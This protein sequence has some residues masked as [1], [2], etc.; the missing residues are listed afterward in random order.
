MNLKIKQ[1]YDHSHLEHLFKRYR[2]QE[3]QHL[4]PTATKQLREKLQHKNK[5]QAV[6][7][8][9]QINICLIAETHLPNEPYM[10]IR[11]YTLQ[12]AVTAHL[13]SAVIIRK[14]ETLEKKFQN[15][16]CK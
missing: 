10:K 16:L 15:I 3:P 6:L 1:R 5:L 14:Y 12:P 11:N 4:N 2:K 8:A 9:Q 13:D 7:R